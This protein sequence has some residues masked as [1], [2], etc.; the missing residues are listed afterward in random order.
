MFSQRNLAKF[1]LVALVSTMFVSAVIPTVPLKE[2]P[3]IQQQCCVDP[4]ST[5]WQTRAVSVN[6]LISR[7]ALHGLDPSTRYCVPR[8]EHGCTRR[9]L[10]ACCT[11][12]NNE[13]QL[14]ILYGSVECMPMEDK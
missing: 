2:C 8:G 4:S 13:L 3:L 11:A 1:L 14:P 12:C 6:E 9:F 5:I 7:A 10:A